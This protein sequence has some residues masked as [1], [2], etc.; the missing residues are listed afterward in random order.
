MGEIAAIGMVR[1]ELAKVGTVL[2]AGISRAIV[3]GK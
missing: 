3:A 1:L 2:S